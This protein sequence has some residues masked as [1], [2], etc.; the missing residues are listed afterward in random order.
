MINSF[1]NHII[2]T[3]SLNPHNKMKNKKYHTVGIIL[4]SNIK[5]IDRDKI[6]IT[7]T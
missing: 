4:K 6:D 7:E 3:N 1:K 5:I 2:N